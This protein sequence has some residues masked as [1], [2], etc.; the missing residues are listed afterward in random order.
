MPPMYQ[1]LGTKFFLISNFITADG[2]HGPSGTL[3]AHRY[4]VA[5]E[6]WEGE[7]FA[8]INSF[9]NKHQMGPMPQSILFINS[10]NP[11]WW[12]AIIHVPSS[13]MGSHRA[14]EGAGRTPQYP[15]SVLSPTSNLSLGQQHRPELR[16]FSG[17]WHCLWQHPQCITSGY[18]QGLLFVY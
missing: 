4:G 11:D 1:G 18:Y 16:P 8:V 6:S 12:D 9:R 14:A 7:R 2:S 17:I 15:Y 3:L 13:T 5:E 10:S